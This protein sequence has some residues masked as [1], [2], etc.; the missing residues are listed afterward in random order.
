MATCI[1]HSVP[2]EGD[3]PPGREGH[4]IV[5]CAWVRDAIMHDDNDMRMSAV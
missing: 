5:E 1:F 4:T 3:V 2:G